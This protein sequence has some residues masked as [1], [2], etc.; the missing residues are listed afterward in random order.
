LNSKEKAKKEQELSRAKKEQELSRPSR[1]LRTITKNGEQCGQESLFFYN[2]CGQESN[3]MGI[4]NW[5]IH[6]ISINNKLVIQLQC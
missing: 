4:N 5:D 6:G 1:I 3:G 2:E